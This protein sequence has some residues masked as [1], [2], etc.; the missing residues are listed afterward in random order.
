MTAALWTGARAWMLGAALYL[1]ESWLTPERAAARQDSGGGPLSRE[2]ALGADV[3]CGKS[4]PPGFTS[5]RSSAMPTLAT[6]PCCAGR[7]TAGSCRTR[8]GISSTL[9]VFRGTPAVARP[10]AQTAQRAAPD[11]LAGH[12]RQPSG[13]R[14]RL[15]AALP[16]RAWRRVT[17]RNGTNRPWAARL[18]CPARHARARLAGPPPRARSLVAAR[19]R[20]RHHAARQSLS[21]ALP[22]TASLRA[23]VRLGPSTLG[24]RAAVSG[25]EGRTRPRSF[26]GSLVSRLASPRRADRARVYLAPIRTATAPARGCRRLPIAR[27]VITEILTAHF[28]VTHPHYL[29]TMMKFRDFHLRI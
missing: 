19:A 16:A 18:R 21:V 28:F 23:L 29:E 5:P 2:V 24:D 7:C 3:A 22:P 10:A 13:S 17:W 8:L 14:A 15:A 25:T 9:T 20:S 11:T 1:P 12:R 27:A 4:A 6:T 26:R